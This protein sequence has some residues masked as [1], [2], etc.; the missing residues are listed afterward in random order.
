MAARLRRIAE[1]GKLTGVDGFGDGID[2]GCFPFERVSVP[3]SIQQEAILAQA[4]LVA[5][6]QHDCAEDP[7]AVDR[8]AVTAAQI[9][10]G[11]F[12]GANANQAVMPTDVGV[13]QPQVAVGTAADEKLFAM[14]GNFTGLVGLIAR[15]DQLG[16]HEFLLSSAW[17]IRDVLPAT[18][19]YSRADAK[20]VPRV[21]RRRGLGDPGPGLALRWLGRFGEIWLPRQSCAKDRT[22]K[23]TAA[24][25]VEPGRPLE[26][27][28]LDVP[29][30][31]P[32]QAL[33]EIVFS[34]V[35]HTQLLEVR[36]HRG[37]D[38]YLPHCLGHEGS[39]I[40]RDVGPGVTKVRPGDAVILS[41]IKGSGAEVTGTVYGWNGR[42]VN[43]GPI[44]T[45]A[46]FAVIS[47]NRLTVVPGAVPLRLAALI[48]C[49][50][51]TGAG[52]VFNTAQ[53]RPGQSVAVF[54]VGGIGLC[55]V[56]AAALAG[57]VPVIAIDLNGDKLALANQLGATH[58]IGAR[59]GDPVEQ[60]R[61]LCP[62]GVDFAIEATGLPAVMRQ[63]LACVRPQGGSA[64][65]VGNARHGQ[66][67]E[68]D[69]RELNQGK[70]LLG[71]WG[72]DTIPERDFPRYCRLMAAGRLNVEPLVP[73]TYRLTE[74]N[75]AL[76]DLEQGRAVRPLLAVGG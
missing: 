67:L 45:F 66:T 72:G 49:A 51:P 40:V 20:P 48:G 37:E 23:T 73:R 19:V 30:L 56:A 46:T 6:F 13:A 71:T 33:V 28:D 29:V 38:R 2:I 10:E 57:C 8:G 12:M 35:C 26:L 68:I 53:P 39:G 47:E 3:A 50:V 27:A 31:R 75:A 18:V 16:R 74:I 42:T 9:G 22:M 61:R 5:G 65:V 60:V 34:G 14:N 32:G 63:A 76:D 59:T 70:R 44:T 43:A 21:G 55:A 69:P 41:W 7:G 25:L 17:G 11:D 4:D 62:G 54:G 36:G 52:V 24:V 58:T 64:V 1:C 15:F